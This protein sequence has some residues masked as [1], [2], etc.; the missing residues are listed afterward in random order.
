MRTRKGRLHAAVALACLI[1]VA[2]P[3]MAQDATDALLLKLKEKGILSEEEYQTLSARKAAAPPAATTVSTTGA[4]GAAPQQAAA[5]ALDDKKLVRVMDSG[6]GMSVGDVNIAFAG[7][8]NGF[9]VHDSGGNT[10]AN[11]QVAGGLASAGPKSSSIRNGLLPGFFKINVTTQQAGWDVGAH[12]GFYPGINSVS[13]VGG[14][15]SAGTPQALATAGIDFRQTYLTFGKPNV[16]EFK[17]GRDI[18]LFAS[19]AI[20]ND[21]T[22]LSVGSTGGNAA[23][24]NT[25]L[26]RIGLGYIY[27]DFQPQITYTTP[28]IGGFQ[29]SVGAFQPLVTIGNNEV[30][31]QP[32]FQGKATYDFTADKFTGHLWVGGITQ[33]HDGL[34]GFPSYTGSGFDAGAKFGYA[35]FTLT[36]Y[37]YGGKG[38]GTTGLFILSTDAAGRKRKSNGWYGQAA[39]TIDKFTIAG[40]YGVSHLSLAK[41]EVNPLLLDDNSSY[42]GQLRYGLTPWVT[43]ISEYVHT[44]STAHGPNKANSDALATGAILFF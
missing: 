7:S 17:I 20:L 39:Y 18:G 16:G 37:Y 30:N 32:G 3:A 35:G 38:I 21:I 19:E 23:P 40:S 13:G 2:S 9:Y 12:F 15:N 36:G 41:G 44:R 10:A 1:G 4:E 24:S 25:S 22:L 5:G 29:A 43:L 28:K 14:A 33:K 11:R 8:V 6:I 27:T 42:V 34:P 26:G 31:K